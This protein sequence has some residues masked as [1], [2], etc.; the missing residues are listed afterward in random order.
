[1]HY[2]HIRIYVSIFSPNVSANNGTDKRCVSTSSTLIDSRNRFTSG[3]FFVKLKTASKGD[4]KIRC[5]NRIS[6]E[7]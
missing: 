4:M 1:M 5:R 7:N 3:S 6:K 2:V